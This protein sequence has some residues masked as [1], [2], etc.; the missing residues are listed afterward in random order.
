M[1]EKI[2]EKPVLEIVVFA[3]CCVRTS[4]GDDGNYG[5]WED[6]NTTPVTSSDSNGF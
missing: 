6:E 3:E 4:Y 5:D 2:Y 1:E